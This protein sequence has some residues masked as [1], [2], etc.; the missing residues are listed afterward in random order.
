MVFKWFCLIVVLPFMIA[1]FTA[2]WVGLFKSDISEAYFKDGIYDALI[3]LYGYPFLKLEV[4]ILI[5][6]VG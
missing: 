2:K 4:K 1:V 3:H 5:I 6:F